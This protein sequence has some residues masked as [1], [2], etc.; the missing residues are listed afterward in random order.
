[1]SDP[2]AYLSLTL[3]VIRHFTSLVGSIDYEFRKGGCWVPRG[4]MP[5]L[6]PFLFSLPDDE[7]DNDG[8]SYVESLVSIKAEI[9]IKKRDAAVFF[10]FHFFHFFLL[11]IRQSLIFTVWNDTSHPEIILLFDHLF[12]LALSQA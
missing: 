7:C 12:V 11:L 10:F 8:S 1:V 2:F 9:L 6:I 3:P 4:S 5:R